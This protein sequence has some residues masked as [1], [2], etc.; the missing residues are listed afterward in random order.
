MQQNVGGLDRTARILLGP[1]LVLAAIA[2]F[3]GYFALGA[4]VGAACLVAGTILLGTGTTQ[5]CPANELAGVD[6]TEQ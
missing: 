4:A 1:I 3:T 6:T 2:A 5:K